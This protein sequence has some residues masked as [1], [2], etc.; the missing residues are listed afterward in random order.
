MFEL[1][2]GVTFSYHLIIWSMVFYICEWCN[3]CYWD[4]CNEYTRIIL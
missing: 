3:S 2:K 4:N 1:K